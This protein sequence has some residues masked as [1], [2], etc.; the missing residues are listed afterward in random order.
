M[1][2]HDDPSVPPGAQLPR[3]FSFHLRKKVSKELELLEGEGIIEKVEGASSRVSSVVVV[4]KPHDLEAI[5]LCI[6]MRMANRAIIRELHVI[7]TIEEIV[8]YLN[9][10]IVFSKLNIRS[11]YKQLE[12]DEDSRS[13]STFRT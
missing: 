6:D 4:P 11:A 10:A 3:H 9:G 5:R 1:K 13:I 8:Q 7:L 2:L 12:L